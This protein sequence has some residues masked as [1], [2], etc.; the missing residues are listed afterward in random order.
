MTCTLANLGLC[1]V[2]Y[3]VD[4]CRVLLFLP[5]HIHVSMWLMTSLE[6]EHVRATDDG[7]YLFGVLPDLVFRTDFGARIK[8]I[9]F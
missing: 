5:L 1:A 4:Q 8:Q 2:L 3:A 7:R 6:C 9:W